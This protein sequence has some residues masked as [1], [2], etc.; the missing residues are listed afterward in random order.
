[1]ACRYVFSI[2]ITVVSTHLVSCPEEARLTC[3]QYNK[4]MFQDEEGKKKIVFPF[5]LFTTCIHMLVQFTLASLV[6]YFLPQLRPGR[7]SGNP[8]HDG[9]H[10]L[11]SDL[12][13]RKSLMTKT[14]YLTR[15]G[16]CGAATGLDIGL[17]NMSLKFISMTFY[18]RLDNI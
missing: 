17:G 11:R 4:W 13:E 7:D 14:F 10:Q 6:L 2:S 9:G 3:F 1:M 15:I 5:P 8:H 16:P 12:E 18:S